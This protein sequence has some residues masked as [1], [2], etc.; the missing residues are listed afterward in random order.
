M[1]ALKNLFEFSKK[2][3]FAIITLLIGIGFIGFFLVFAVYFIRP[4]TT[5]NS[6]LSDSITFAVKYFP[7][8]K[9]QKPTATFNF[10]DP[11]ISVVS[12][13]LNPFPFN[14]NKLPEEKWRELGLKE[15]QIRNILNYEQKGGKFLKKEDFGKLYTITSEEY[16]LLAPYI[17]LPSPDQMPLV[18]QETRKL[19]MEDASD[20]TTASFTEHR[21]EP[22]ELNTADSIDLIKIPGIT[23]WLAFRILKYRS[24]LGNFYSTEQLHEIYGMDSLRMLQVAMYVYIDSAQI[25]K[26]AVNHLEFKELLQHPYF[27]FEQVKRILNYRNRR[28]FINSGSQ[29][30]EITGMDSVVFNKLRPYLNFI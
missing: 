10:S 26:L 7:E 1:N 13:Q 21:L 2:E 5:E 27:N 19:L 11:D 14:P 24:I 29:L 9:V 28:G 6:S 8:S 3:Q 15:H 17:E 23:L 12:I 22:V 25:N 4:F 16:K 30:M 20:K 18:N